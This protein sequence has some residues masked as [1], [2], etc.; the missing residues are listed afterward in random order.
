MDRYERII[1]DVQQKTEEG[2]VQW[3]V[4]T[5]GLHGRVLMSPDRVVRACRADYRLAQKNYTLLFVERRVDR[6]GE[7]AEPLEL[8][9]FEL[10]VLDKDGEI[11]IPLYD[12]LVDFDDLAKLAGLIAER[13]DRAKEF[14]A[15]F[16]GTSAA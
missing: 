10:L 1:H 12:G 4:V 7:S 3:K 13:N 6:Y 11:V 8:T 9:A 15:A 5:P 16:D 2:A 14:F